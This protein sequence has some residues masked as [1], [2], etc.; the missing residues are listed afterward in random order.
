VESHAGIKKRWLDRY[1]STGGG[2]K[3]EAKYRRWRKRLA[4]WR[5]C[6]V[7]NA[8]LGRAPAARSILDV[9]CGPGRFF[10]VLSRHAAAVHLGDISPEMLAIA[11]NR[12][13]NRAAGYHQLNLV[14]G[15]DLGRQFDG[16]VSVRLMHHL[17]SPDA[18]GAYLDSLARLGEHWIIL[19][20]RD[21]RAP[22]TVTR[23]ITRCLTGERFLA[24]LPRLARRLRP[25]A[26]LVHRGL[27]R[28]HPQLSGGLP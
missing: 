21:V 19:T 10:D 15:A 6:S 28:T 16:V 20:F 25:D 26:I 9:P 3:Y 2:Q 27:C 4:H 11:R 12:T 14:N 22:R 23:Q 8:L 24:A 5:E 1:L 17:Y 13:E 7:L 18:R